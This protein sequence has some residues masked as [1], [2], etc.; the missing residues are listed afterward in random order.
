MTE[1]ID[2]LLAARDHALA[3]RDAMATSLREMVAIV[4]KEA[5]Y[6]THEKQGQL[7]HARA[8]LAECEGGR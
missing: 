7:R 6:M 4:E 1:S 2:Q 5:G 3:Q 8:L